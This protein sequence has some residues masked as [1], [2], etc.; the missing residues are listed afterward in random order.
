MNRSNR[1]TK[2]AKAAPLARATWF[3]FPLLLALILAALFWKSFLPGYVAFSNDGPLGEQHAAWCRLP[4]ALTGMWYDQNDIGSSAGAFSTDITSLCGWILGPFG[5]SKFYCAI[6]LFILGM[7]AWTFFRQLKLSPLAAALGALATAL[8]SAYFGNACWGTSPQQTAMGMV[9]FALA[10]V[11]ANSD[12]SR[13]WIYWTRLALAGMAVGISVMEGADNGAIFSVFVAAY[14][15]FQSVISKI[16][17]PKIEHIIVWISCN[18]LLLAALSLFFILHSGLGMKFVPAAALLLGVT[19]W[20]CAM[21][22]P[23]MPAKR[24]AHGIAHVILIAIFAFLIAAQTV[25]ALVGTYIIGVAGI[26]SDKSAE[27][28]LEHWD[29]ATQWSLPKK[30]TLGVFVPG[31]FGYR[32][33]T[34]KDMMKPLQP[35]Y[36]GGQYWGGMGRTPAID[37]FFDSGAPGSPPP[38]MMRFGYGGF[39]CGILVALVALFAIVQS[40]RR[41]SSIFSKVQRHFIWFWTAALI[42]ALLLAWGRFAPFYRLF[43]M[44]PGAS[45]IRNPAK[46]MQIFYLAMVII[47]AYG[48]DALSRVY[49]QTATGKSSSWISQFKQ[50]RTS[51]RGFDRNW[52]LFCVALFAAS[53]VAWL[54][55]WSQKARLADYLQ[56]VGFDGDTATMIAAFSVGQVGWFLLFLGGAIGLMILVLAGVFSGRR[57]KFGGILL[58]VL[59]VVDLGR[60]NLPWIIHWNY[61]EKYASNYI[62]DILRDKPYEHRVADLRSE[63]LFEELYRIEWMQHHFPY[64]NIQCLDIIQSPRVASDLEAYDADLTPTSTN[65]TY[66]IA[67]HWELTNTRYFLGP[68]NYLDSV[69]DELDPVQRR[70]RI[71][72]RFDVVPKPGIEHP[73]ELE[74]LTAVPDDN[75][76]YALFD[77]TGAL[78]RASLYSNW[79]VDTNDNATL[80]TLAAKNFHPH[81]TVLVSSIIP[82]EPMT[83]TTTG[84]AGTVDYKSYAPKDIV[85]SAHVENPAVLLLNDKFD[86]NWRV[87]VDGKPAELLRCNFIMR[88]VFLP[89]GNHTVEFQFD[90][91][92]KLL[93]VTFAAIVL[94]ILM[95]AILFIFRRKPPTSPNNDAVG[96]SFSEQKK[97]SRPQAIE[98]RP[99]NQDVRRATG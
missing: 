31:L 2:A 25:A 96:T 29:W 55:Y 70:F 88:G 21:A 45:T 81:Q 67:R 30:E 41:Q 83:N 3:P 71:A 4:A 72:Q 74:Q 16:S 58:G 20:N 14:V 93:Y 39:Y 56:R 53:V 65:N 9:F 94:G 15:V 46:F 12:E 97:G 10:L 89:P 11:M 7:G 95:G 61:K 82:G 28:P 73:T 64:Y 51:V 6:A 62:I 32:M 52:S 99:R 79:Q 35:H 19:A 87:L 77:F 78:P 50:W 75:G 27:T 76:E 42:I 40:L 86:P 5:Y 69:N 8:N 34:P 36:Q 66:L 84:D 47:F 1:D 24:V 91:P 57:A 22:V 59:L 13:R 38:G 44:L 37:R 54:V 85:L 49:L 68:A 26:G 17:W 63:S 92:H 60:A 80:K 43:Y 33:D 48:V 18:L 98:A 23:Y 90:L